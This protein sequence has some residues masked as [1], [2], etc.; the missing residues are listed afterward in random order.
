MI[1]SKGVIVLLDALKILKDKGYSFVCDFVGGETKE[2]DGNRFEQEVNNRGLDQLVK[3]HG[4]MYGQDKD[5]LFSN[6]DIFAFPTFYNNE[7][8]ALSEENEKKRINCCF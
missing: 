2:I 3:Y 4:K 7:S 1:I 6:A 5:S 8:I